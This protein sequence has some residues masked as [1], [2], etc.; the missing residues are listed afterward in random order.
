MHQGNNKMRSNDLFNKLKLQY[1]SKLHFLK[2][3]PDETID[4]T[5]IACWQYASGKRFSADKAVT[6]PLPELNQEQIV[7]LKDLLELRIKNIPL[8][9]ILGRQCFLGID[10][11]SDNRALIPRKETEILGRKALNLSLEIAQKKDI[12]HAMDVCC[13]SGNLGL[14]VTYLNPKVR[15]SASDLSD[16]AVQLANENRLQLK[17][18]ER[19][20]IERGDLFSA[21]DHKKYYG[22]MDLIICNPPYISTAK[23][24]KMEE[25]ISSHEPKLAFDGGMF[26]FNIIRTLIEQSPKFLRQNGWLTFEVGLGQGEFI[27]QLCERNENYENIELIQDDIGN[28]RVLAIQKR[29]NSQIP[30]S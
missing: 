28:I 15:M 12:V 17:L 16:E 26:G 2:D 4:F 24:M 30:G 19:V 23:V 25:E 9:H 27:K 7:T 10:F 18:E 3:K 6:Y 13:G 8:A 29:G 21:F 5:I 22:N 1:A 20:E 11:L 14:A